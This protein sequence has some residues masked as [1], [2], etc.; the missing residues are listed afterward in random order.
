MT[1]VITIPV[2]SRDRAGKG[3]ARA[4]RRE[5]LVPGVIYG[6][7]QAPVLFKMDPR[8]LMAQLKRAGFY[9]HQYELEVD[10]KKHR[11]MAQDVQFHVVTDQPIHVDFLRINKNTIVTASVSV[12]FD[13]QDTCPGL[14]E[15]GV[16]NIVRHDIEVH[17]KP[18][19]LP[20]S[21]VVDLSK[22]ALNES[23]H[24]SS[25]T[26]PK[27]VT[28]VIADRDFTICTIAAPSGLRSEKSEGG[29]DE[30]TEE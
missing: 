25:V 19:D 30:A 12:H 11:V 21:I 17:A 29:D 24:I 1:D 23:V 14:K 2:Q 16:L 6:D 5:G 7:K 18:D 26:L 8:P 28:P 3:A 10:G 13:N 15:G 20:E 22:V 9:T 27:G 4:V